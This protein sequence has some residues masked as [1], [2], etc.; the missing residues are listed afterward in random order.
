MLKRRFIRDPSDAPMVLASV[1][2]VQLSLQSF[3]Q[4]VATIFLSHIGVRERK[5][6]L[7]HWHQRFPWKSSSSWWCPCTAPRGCTAASALSR[8]PSPPA[9]RCACH[10]RRGRRRTPSRIYRPQRWTRS[11][12]PHARHSSPH[13][14]ATHA[15]EGAGPA[16][17]LRE[18]VLHVA[19]VEPEHRRPIATRREGGTPG[20]RPAGGTCPLS[21]SSP[22]WSYTARF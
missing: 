15:A 22:Y 14:A 20:A 2:P 16:Q 7:T 9:S 18:D 17:E 4:L 1:Q 21:P 19:R 3:V 5:E 6:T 10:A 13:A 11:T 8:A 12:G